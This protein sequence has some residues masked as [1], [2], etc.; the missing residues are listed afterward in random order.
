MKHHSF[1]FLK[2][3]LVSGRNTQY[4]CLSGS[5]PVPEVI[6]IL[7][8]PLLPSKTWQGTNTILIA[9]SE[10]WLTGPPAQCDSETCSSHSKMSRPFPKECVFLFFILKR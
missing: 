9:V 6:E 8:N 2:S 10:E 5:M 7:Q 4:T 3:G 1:C